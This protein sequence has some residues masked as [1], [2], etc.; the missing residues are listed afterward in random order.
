MS[1]SSERGKEKGKV[2]SLYTPPREFYDLEEDYKQQ[3]KQIKKNNKKK[4]QEEEEDE[5]DE[6]ASDQDDSGY[7][8]ASTSRKKRKKAVKGGKG[9][10]EQKQKRGGKEIKGPSIFERKNV[11]T[12]II[13]RILSFA[14]LESVYHLSQISQSFHSILSSKKKKTIKKIWA[15][16]KERVE[17]ELPEEVTELNERQLA[18]LLFGKQCYFDGCTKEGQGD[19]FLRVILCK[20]HRKEEL[21]NAT[22]MSSE[23]PELM[24][25]APECC[26]S[27]FSWVFRYQ[28]EDESE[29]LLSKEQRDVDEA[30][31][32]KWNEIQQGTAKNRKGFYFAEFDEKLPK[33]GTGKRV[34]S[35][36]EKRKKKLKVF[37]EE[38]RALYN[39]MEKRKD[40]LEKEKEELGNER[41]EAIEERMLDLEGYSEED[42]EDDHW[43]KN[44]LIVTGSSEID[45]QAWE[46]LEPKVIKVIEHCRKMKEKEEQKAHLEARLKHLRSL[47]DKVRDGE[48]EYPL[49]PDWCILPS[50]LKLI[51]LKDTES[52]QIDKKRWG[53]LKEEIV[54]EA[55]GWFDDI[56]L[57]LVKL[58]LSRTLDLE[59]EEQLDDDPESYSPYLEDDEWFKCAQSLVCCDIPNCQTLSNDHQVFFGAIDDLMTHQHEVHSDLTP[60]FT[61]KKSNPFRLR[62]S[63]PLPVACAITDLLELGGFEKSDDEDRWDTTEE[64]ID[65]LFEGKQ[66][67]LQW[68]NAPRTVFGKSKK[69]SDWKKII[70]KIKIESDRAEKNKE[71]LNPSLVMWEVVNGKPRKKKKKK[72]ESAVEKN[73]KKKKK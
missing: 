56:K 67:L 18:H 68:E 31:E 44:K 11:P 17:P 60:K 65:E 66:T 45:D 4:Q 51:D 37:E 14:D 73:V 69:E 63:L 32:E 3:A 20:T 42:F 10:K 52:E 7:L 62:F 23:Y 16:A 71:V 35:Y 2:K 9:K 21:F 5:I 13:L 12:E 41:R 46:E 38:G 22:K 15:Q 1:R 53:E 29:I 47:Y 48:T 54:Q 30:E 6:L 50:V 24:H 59:D 70:S 57:E 28:A 55:N 40:D 39:W 33:A 72:S 58:V 26:L 43:K 61:L 8:S 49:F 25:Q 36:V 64:E 27:T 34:M 19:P